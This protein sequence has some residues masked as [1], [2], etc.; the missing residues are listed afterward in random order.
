MSLVDETMEK[1]L[2][3]WEVPRHS[4]PIGVSEDGTKIYLDLGYKFEETVSDKLVLEVSETGL[5]IRAANEVNVQEGEWIE[6]HPTDPK[7]AYLSFER[8]R[9][10]D[11]SYI[12][13]F[14]APCT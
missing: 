12:I 7:N 2:R 1:R 4:I 8:F 9:V 11:R 14:T 10:G 3:T 6:N 5:A 13:R